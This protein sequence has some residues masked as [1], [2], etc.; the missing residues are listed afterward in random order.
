MKGR[1][2]VV[3]TAALVVLGAAPLFGAGEPDPAE[4]RT[5]RMGMMEE[6]HTPAGEAAAMFA[7]LVEEYTNGDFPVEV[8]YGGALGETGDAIEDVMDGSI[9]LWWGGIS[10]YEEVVDDFRIFSLNWAFDDNA[11]LERF[12]QSDRFQVEMLDELRELD[13]EMIGYH[14]FRNPRNV[15]SRVPI[16]DIDDFDGLLIR[17]PPQPLYR[18]SWAAVGTSPTELDYGEVY[19]ALSQGV[20]EAMENP[21]ESIYGQSFQEQATYLVETNH[22]LNP[23]SISVNLDLFEAL[24]PE[25][26]DAFR[27]AAEESGEWFSSIIDEEEAQIRQLFEDEYGVTFVEVDTGVLAEKV[28]PV[29]GELEAEGQISDGLFEYARGYAD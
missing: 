28:L 26:Q 25:Y 29:V 23:Y 15:L 2:I 9:E 1:C 20:I 10:W 21:I 24:S 5:L 13:L 19:T 12:L 8:Y 7:E 4:P 22:L 11:H 14:A 27:R 6:S 16:E 17:V 18:Q 3:L